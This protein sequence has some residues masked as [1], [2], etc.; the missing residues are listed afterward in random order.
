VP[1][2][3]IRRFPSCA[4]G[5]FGNAEACLRTESG[6]KPPHS[7][8]Y[9]RVSLET[10]A[11]PVI[12]ALPCR[13]GDRHDLTA[14]PFL[15]LPRLSSRRHLLFLRPAPV[16]PVQAVED[17][18]GQRHRFGYLFLGLRMLLVSADVL[19]DG[20]LML[21]SAH[22]LPHGAPEELASGLAGFGAGGGN[23]AGWAQTVISRRQ[24]EQS[25]TSPS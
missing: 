6:G 19:L 5:L 13:H 24:G 18:L 10:S 20:L 4:P 7:K 22:G 21:R 8:A 17:I 3:S 12:H 9:G 14:H 25:S 2:L 11:V 15:G 16:L 1:G 23:D